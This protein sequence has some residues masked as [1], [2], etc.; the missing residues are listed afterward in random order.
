MA[1]IKRHLISGLVIAAIVL[2]AFYAL[3]RPQQPIPLAEIEAGAPETLVARVVEVL[4]RGSANPSGEVEQPYQR[5]RLRVESGSLAGQDIEAEQGDM[6]FSTEERLLNPGDRVYVDRMQGVDG[7]QFFISDPVRTQPLLL[8]AGLFVGLILLTARGKGLRALA[9]TIFSLIV[10]F[11]YVVPQILAGRDPL[12]VSIAGAIVLLG[13]TN[14]LVYGWNRKAHAALMGMALSLMLTG[15]LAWA[16][17]EATRLSGLSTE[18]GSYLVME[19]GPR[20]QFHRLLLGGIIIGSL[21]VLDDI[22]VSQAAAVFEL[23]QANPKLGWKGLFRHSLNIGQDHVAASVNT[24]LLAYAGASLP[25]LL[26]FTLYQEPL[27]RRLSR[28]PVTEEIIRTL[29]GTVGL[30]LAMPLTGLIASLLA[31]RP[32]AQPAEGSVE[33]CA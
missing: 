7:D 16:F 15:V 6:L 27:W 28:E 26:V 30:V 20:V 25:L 3:S 9:G 31:Q 8:V 22:C 21:G 2:G 32:V 18:E 12:L 19:M 11:A 17:V 1:V 4:E 23:A 14:Y 33:L 10:I 29:V 5:L 13:V 24:L